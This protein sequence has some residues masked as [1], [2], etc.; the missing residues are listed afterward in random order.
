M[1]LGNACLKSKQ[2][3]VEPA[4]AGDPTDKLILDREG[5]GGSYFIS[6]LGGS[7]EVQSCLHWQKRGISQE[8]R[9]RQAWSRYK[10]GI[11]L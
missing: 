6:V 8:W 5:W 10:K 1:K 2:G 7:R 9:G 11:T 3:Q 4:L